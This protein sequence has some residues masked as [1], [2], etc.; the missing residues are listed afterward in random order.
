[1]KGVK[2][3]LRLTTS[4]GAIY[5]NS[6][7]LHLIFN[8]TAVIASTVLEWV[9]PPLS[10]R[11]MEACA[12]FKSGMYSGNIHLPRD[13]YLIDKFFFVSAG[14]PFIQSKLEL[15]PS[16]QM[17][18]ITDQILSTEL[19]RPLF[20]ALH[21]QNNLTT[22]DVSNSFIGD[23]GVK[24]LSQALPTLTHLAVINLCGNLVTAAGIKH[25]ESVCDVHSNCL[26]ELKELYLS[27]NPLQNASL[28]SLSNICSKLPKLDT[29]HL[30]SADLTHLQEF[31]LGFNSLCDL[32]L[33]Y[34]AFGHDAITKA[35]EK[36]NTCKIKQLNLSYCCPQGLDDY[37]HDGERSRDELKSTIE[38]LIRVLDSGM[39]TNLQEIH[40]SGWGLN[41]VDCWRLI[42]SINRSK[43]LRVLSLRDNIQLSKV[44]FKHIL[45]TIAV[46]QLHL[47]GCKMLL[48]GLSEVDAEGFQ[49]GNCPESITL[50][51]PTASINSDEINALKQWWN[52]ASRAR[53][54]LF[55]KGTMGHLTL[56]LDAFNKIWGH[57]LL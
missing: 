27:F 12:Q 35:I 22:I 43:V 4:D 38:T 47:E 41:D 25:I 3:V 11:Y 17:L 19:C 52:I 9:T 20:R 53:G 48:C 34:N 28:L 31:D 55:V 40:L 39:C 1:M 46:K 5:E 21:F 10:Q 45:E 14:D 56:K 51:L 30:A 24:H 29:L 2:P 44:T 15:I 23:D 13:Q 7:P 32:D 26:A 37:G 54:R 33:S 36:L 6:D 18:S 50:T 8:E 16:S 42:Q 57:S 49:S